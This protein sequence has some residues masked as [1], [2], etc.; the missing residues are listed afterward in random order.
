MY[1]AGRFG[2]SR[3][4]SKWERL[5]ILPIPMFACM[6]EIGRSVL[7]CVTEYPII[8]YTRRL[9]YEMEGRTREGEGEGGEREG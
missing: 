7:L 2:W 4:G 1:M 6:I 3:V 5:R 9:V 8:F